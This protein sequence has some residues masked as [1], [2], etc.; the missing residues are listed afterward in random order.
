MKTKILHLESYD[1]LHSIKDKISWGTGEQVVL[2]WPIRGQ[3]VHT[4][5]DMLLI[6]R[7]VQNIGAKLALVTKNNRVREFASQLDIPVFRSLRQ[8][9]TLPWEYT[10]EE[11][12]PV[13]QKVRERVNLLELRDA[14]HP[15]FVPTWSNHPTTRI[16]AFLAGVAA[17]LTLLGFLLPRAEITLAPK[18]ET[19]ELTLTI[20]ANP[21]LLSSNLSGAV[22]AQKITIVV[23]G[24][25]SIRPSGQIGIP[26]QAAAG[27]AEFT[28]L[29]DQ[30]ISI[31][32]GTVV[33]TLDSPPIRFAT[34]ANGV[35]S[36]SPGETI[37]LPITALNP[38]PENNLPAESLTVIEGKL[39][40]S[41]TVTNP[42]PTTGGTEQIS[43]A[44]KP[45]DYDQ[46]SDDLLGALWETA[47]EEAEKG[48]APNDII[49]DQVPQSV[50]ILE[51]TFDP[52][53]PQPSSELTLILRVEYE[54]SV[55]SGETFYEMVNA[56]LDATLQEGYSAMR[57]TLEITPNS[58][59]T[60][61]EDGSVIWVILAQR[62]IF[63][64]ED[65][66]AVIQSILGQTP[67]QA[68]KT[69]SDN[70]SLNTAPEITITPS[71]WPWLPF[72]ELQIT[73]SDE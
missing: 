56:I 53:E 41:L 17:S 3:L 51:E 10:V 12:K 18:T 24:R 37:T 65:K 60:F 15:P 46:L 52:P 57:D 16:I 71:W 11:S 49:L 31:P 27:E 38:G 73:V 44:P 13:K 19:Q 4:K 8:A 42:A 7:H 36:A 68:V 72:L 34:A 61:Q 29:T 48:L 64:L 67:T 5:L 54:L 20:T 32:K 47:L 26:Q 30:P 23:E 28:N 69:L 14:A 6:Q 1:D 45:E 58:A 70:F 21:A 50:T 25:D 39:G 66:H 9:N 59:Y 2:I 40:L 35:L 63:S 33:R 62:G 22:P 55:V 43:A